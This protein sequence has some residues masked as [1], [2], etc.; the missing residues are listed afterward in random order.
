MVWLAIGLDTIHFS[1]MFQQLKAYNIANMRPKIL[2][3]GKHANFNMRHLNTV[4][5]FKLL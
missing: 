2:K 1:L 5:L 3:L 4:S